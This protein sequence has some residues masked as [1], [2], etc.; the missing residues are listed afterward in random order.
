MPESI[1]VTAVIPAP[2]E[3]IY[4]SW[5]SSREHGKFTGGEARISPK[6]GGKFTAWDGYISGTNIEL[7]PFDRIVQAWRTTEFSKDDPD[8]LIEI[9]FEEQKGKTKITLKHT[10]IPA[11]QGSGYKKGWKDFYFSPMK[12]YFGK[13]G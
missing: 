13:Q 5:L 3:R 1:L 6:K 12:E 9:I 2:K 8:S 11:G 7:E 4:K 10:N